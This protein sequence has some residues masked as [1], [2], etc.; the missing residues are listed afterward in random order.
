MAYNAR[1]TRINGFLPLR[2]PLTSSTD[3]LSLDEKKWICPNLLMAN[4]SQKC[5][6]CIRNKSG[7]RIVNAT[8]AYGFYMG[9]L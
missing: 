8:F 3:I 2:D 5:E 7:A 9:L 1:F 6:N 4:V